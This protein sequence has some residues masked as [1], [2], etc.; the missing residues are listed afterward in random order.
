MN[1]TGTSLNA[2]V[3]SIRKVA[4]IVADIATA[5][6]EQ[7][8]GLDQINKALAQ[9][10]EVTQQNSAL[11]EE[12]A[13]TAKTL[14]Q[15]AGAMTEQ[16][17][18][19]RLEARDGGAV[20]PSTAPIVSPLKPAQAGAETRRRRR[21]YAGPARDRVQVRRGTKSFKAA[22]GARAIP[23]S[24]TSVPLARDDPDPGASHFAPGF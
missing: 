18:F 12:N 20:R 8:T 3:T 16:V 19:F 5:S 24:R 13:A 2:I 1:R 4:E 7:S 10:D 17:S 9:M 22:R 21:P 14:E 6:A 15:Q 23:V 11:V